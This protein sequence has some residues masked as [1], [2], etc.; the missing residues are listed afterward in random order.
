V[1]YGY[2]AMAFMNDLMFYAGT[3]SGGVQDLKDQGKPSRHGEKFPA[4][5]DVMVVRGK[6]LPGYPR[7]A[8]AGTPLVAGDLVCFASIKG[9][10]RI[11]KPDPASLGEKHVKAETVWSGAL[12]S[13]CHSSPVAAEG[14][15]VVGCDDENLYC[16]R[17]K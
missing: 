14:C 9:E 3:G 12:G 5:K 4:L 8:S 7:L 6:G 1:S 2:N 16:F 17:G 10:L 15:L 13:T 11:L